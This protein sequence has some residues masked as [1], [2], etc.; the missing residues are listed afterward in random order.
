MGGHVDAGT[1]DYAVVAPT[2]EAGKVRIL[3]TFNKM[4]EKPEI[5]SLAEL[6][7]KDVVIEKMRG[8]VAPKGTPPEVIDLLVEVLR[9]AYDDAEFQTYYRTSSLTPDFRPKEEYQKAMDYQY[10]LVK[11][12]YGK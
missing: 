4:A 8:V 11:S 2:A 5:P 10:E 1:E 6:G 7:Y 9:T 3:A 12:F